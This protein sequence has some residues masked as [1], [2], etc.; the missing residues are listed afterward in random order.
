MRSISTTT[1][2]DVPPDVAWAALAD[3]A[4]HAAWNPFMVRLEGEPRVGSRLLVELAPPGGRPMTFRPVV[5][6]VE[7]GRRLQ[8]LG[9]LGVRGLFDG[10]HDFLLDPLPEGRSRLTHSETF[11]G[12]LVPLVWRSMRDRTTAGFEA[13]NTAFARRCSVRANDRSTGPKPTPSPSAVVP[14]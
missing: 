2:L 9:H 14:S 1:D 13:F 5:T 12:L 11:S 3:F 7:P 10:R 6:A 4:D 8:W